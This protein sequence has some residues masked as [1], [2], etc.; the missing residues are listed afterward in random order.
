MKSPIAASPG[1]SPSSLTRPAS[2]ASSVSTDFIEF[3]EYDFRSPSWLYPSDKDSKLVH[4][5]KHCT[6]QSSDQNRP[7]DLNSFLQ[8]FGFVFSVS[9][10]QILTEY[11]V[12]GFTVILPSL[13]SQGIVP[14]A[15]SI[16]PAAVFPLAIAST[17]LIFGR[18]ADMY[19][20]RSIY[21]Y[22]FI[23]LAIWSVIIGFSNNEVMMIISRAMQGIGA[24]AILPSGLM[25]MGATYHPGTRKNMVFCIFGACGP[26]G[27][28]LG[29]FVAGVAAATTETTGPMVFKPESGLTAHSRRG[30]GNPNGL[31]WGK[32]VG[33]LRQPHSVFI[34][35]LVSSTSRMEDALHLCLAWI[36]A[37]LLFAVAPQ[38][39]NYWGYIFPSMMCATI[40]IDVTFNVCNIHITT[41]TTRNQQG[42][43]GA[44]IAFL[45]HCG[46][47]MCLGLADIVKRETQNVLGDRK[48]CQ[49]VFW[50]EVGC[51]IIATLILV[52]F[53]RVGE[54]K[55]DL[56]VEEK[57]EAAEKEENQH[58]GK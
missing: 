58:S 46:G 18:L 23:W 41:N 26:F 54:A 48:S 8:E 6:L 35:R 9:M 3:K 27:F 7:E 52:A 13:V 31:G 32:S 17:T 33:Y 50:L 44:I 47:T 14:E 5:V 28:F 4:D 22:G 16:W 24:S 51:A 45:L 43:A 36:T 20:G 30:Q 49:A 53:V 39:A 19:G 1:K 10:S 11:L 57:L 25:L 37:P 12:S 21:L 55:N 15:S 40:G 29:I 42:F 34:N 2:L 38:D 56:R